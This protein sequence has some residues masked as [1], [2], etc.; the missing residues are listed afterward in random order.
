VGVDGDGDDDGD[1]GLGK[2]FLERRVEE[3]SM[4]VSFSDRSYRSWDHQTVRGT[5]LSDARM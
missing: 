3:V 2:T 1:G 4:L 5:S